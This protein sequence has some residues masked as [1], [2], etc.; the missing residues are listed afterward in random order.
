MQQVSEYLGSRYPFT[1]RVWMFLYSTVKYS[2]QILTLPFARLLLQVASSFSL[3]RWIKSLKMIYKKRTVCLFTTIS[4]M[5]ICLKSK[6]SRPYVQ[7]KIS[8]CFHGIYI[9]TYFHSFLCLLIYSVS[10]D[11]IFVFMNTNIFH[12]IF[13]APGCNPP[14][15]AWWYLVRLLSLE[16]RSR[17]C[18]KYC[19]V[20]KQSWL[21][22]SFC[23]FTAIKKKT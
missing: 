2:T 21:W 15:V 8:V 23:Q 10:I 16:R 1:F 12:H 6:H 20:W 11:F 22:F 4:A 19:S 14:S 7:L 13:A 3:L 5:Y 9:F 17:L 18:S